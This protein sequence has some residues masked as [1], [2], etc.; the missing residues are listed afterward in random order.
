MTDAA[1]FLHRVQASG[2]KY[3]GNSRSTGFWRTGIYTEISSG[4]RVN[5]GLT[6]GAVQSPHKSDNTAGRGYGERQGMGPL[7]NTPG[8]VE[9]K[10]RHFI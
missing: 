3:V 9:R 7:D 6:Q 4:S 5:T 1:H 10:G 8:I 2:G